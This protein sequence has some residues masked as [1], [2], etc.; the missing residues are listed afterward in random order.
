MPGQEYPT[1]VGVVNQA[2]DYPTGYT[3]QTLE[4]PT[5]YGN[6]YGEGGTMMYGT[7]PMYGA[8]Q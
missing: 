4:Y 6:M 5:G 2:V 7:N 1:G 8:K 3:T